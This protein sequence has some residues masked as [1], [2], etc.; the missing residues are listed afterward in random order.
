M[1]FVTQ[2]S[3]ANVVNVSA[4]SVSLVHSIFT[5]PLISPVFWQPSAILISPKSFVLF[6]VQSSVANNV[7]L[8]DVAVVMESAR[9]AK[10]IDRMLGVTGYCRRG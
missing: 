4:L 1:K 6:P 7:A 3:V 9:L 8:N 2:Q 10:N 5:L